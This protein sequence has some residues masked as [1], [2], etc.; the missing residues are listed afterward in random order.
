M[1][2]VVSYIIIL[3]ITVNCVLI[4]CCM[5]LFVCVWICKM[6]VKA[7][8]HYLYMRYAFDAITYYNDV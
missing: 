8:D 6:K 3:V 4:L 1:F 7:I 2:T 5:V